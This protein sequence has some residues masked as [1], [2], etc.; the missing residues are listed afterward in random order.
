MAHCGRDARLLADLTNYSACGTNTTC[1]IN[2]AGTGYWRGAFQ[3]KRLIT[4]YD[5]PTYA[6]GNAFMNVG[7]WECDAQ[8]CSIRC[9]SNSPD[10]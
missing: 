9:E 7:A 2:A 3:P 4:I 10:G 1:N 8:P 5:G 6:D